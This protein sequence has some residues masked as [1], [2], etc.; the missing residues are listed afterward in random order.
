[1]QVHQYG[2][3]GFFFIVSNPVGHLHVYYP[4]EGANDTCAGRQTTDV[5]AQE[6]R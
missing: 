3:D 4:S 2:V 5:Q 6:V 1:M